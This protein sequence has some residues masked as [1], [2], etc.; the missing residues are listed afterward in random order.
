L[1]YNVFPEQGGQLKK[2]LIVAACLLFAG[3]VFAAGRIKVVTSITPLYNI[4]KA[5]AG[6]AADISVIVPPGLSPHMFSPKPSQ[7]VDM[8][9]ADVFIKAGAGLEYWADKIV[10]S[11]GNKKLAIVTVTD[12]L[13][14]EGGDSDAP[15]G[16]PHVWLDPVLVKA[17]SASI[18]KALA[19]ADPANKGLYERN[20]KKFAAELDALDRMLAAE[21]GK[22]RIK[23]LVSFHP[24]WFYFEKRYGLT[25]A[26]SIEAVPG[27][28][29]SAREIQ[30]IIELVKKYGI[31]AV[32]AEST[33]PRKAADVIA[34]EAGVKVAVLSPEGGAGEDYITF[35]KNN[36]QIMQEAMK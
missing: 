20:Y 6:G 29:P 34:A 16:N 8:A 3:G 11:S 18:E 28:E 36:F 10:S 5:I 9:K 19:A 2:A 32:F 26:A 15:S 27:R 22:F 17:F 23:E 12:G 33:L 35:M 13:K 4:T 31:K 1:V 25:E 14:L 30:G 7:L 24:S 21:T